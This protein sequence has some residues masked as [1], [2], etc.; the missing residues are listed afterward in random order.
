[1]SESILYAVQFWKG[2]KNIYT[3]R[4][5]ATNAMSAVELAEEY[6]KAHVYIPGKEY[7]LI[8]VNSFT[9]DMTF[10]T[11]KVYYKRIFPDESVEYGIRTYN[12]NEEDDI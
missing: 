5:F 2:D 3:S 9:E 7:D 8:K 4:H 12:I 10:K 1:M 11:F 6:F